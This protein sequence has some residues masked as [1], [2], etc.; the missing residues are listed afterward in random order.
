MWAQVAIVLSLFAVA[1]SVGAESGISTVPGVARFQIYTRCA[2]V[3]LIVERLPEGA[4]RIGLKDEDLSV[5]VESRLRSASLYQSER[6]GFHEGSYFS[7][8]LLVLNVN[9]LGPAFSVSLKLKKM[10]KIRF[11][12]YRFLRQPGR[13]ERLGHMAMVEAD[14]FCPRSVPTSTD[15]S[16]SGTR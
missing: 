9:V 5:A 12:R 7:Y 11:P 2:G 13:S 1:Q 8:P 10:C 6:H 14:T 3:N 15:S 16:M 4:A